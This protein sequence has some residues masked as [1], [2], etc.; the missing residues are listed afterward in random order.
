MYIYKYSLIPHPV[1]WRGPGPI[2]S[3]NVCMSDG[4]VRQ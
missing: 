4:K 1:Y 2:F 3:G